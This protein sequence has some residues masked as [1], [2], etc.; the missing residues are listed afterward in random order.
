[1]LELMKIELDPYWKTR[2][3][4]DKI[5]AWMNRTGMCRKTWYNYLAKYYAAIGKPLP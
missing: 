3:V 4:T 5:E 2:P 1:M